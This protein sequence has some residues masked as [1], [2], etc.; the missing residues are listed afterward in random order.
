MQDLPV[1]IALPGPLGA[2]VAGWVEAEGWQVV[3]LDDGLRPGLLLAAQVVATHPCV[4]V[5][6]GPPSA[7]EVRTALQA[8]ALDVVGWPDDADRIR[9]LPS[10]V[11]GLE[12]EG[13]AGGPRR[14]TVAGVAGGV[15]TSTVALAIGALLAWSGREVLVV[16]DADLLALC[17][18][19]PWRGPGS[20]EVALLGPAGAADEIPALSRP[21][22]GV[23]GLRVLGG[24]ADTLLDT[25]GWPCDA[26]VLD[27]RTAGRM[28]ADL[29]CARPDAHLPA[30]AEAGGGV[31]LLGDGPLGSR[32][33]HAALGRR[34]AGR[35]PDSARVARAGAAG[36]VPSALPGSWLRTLRAAL[37]GG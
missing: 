1:A 24:G 2:E 36:R 16:G 34:V 30:A 21:V 5:V 25:G 29:L 27:L 8:G 7:E 37:V 11:R 18:V 28:E 31:L 22:P 9:A 13:T 12:R 15:G 17:A 35:L 19:D 23:A 20:A 26:V 14:L 32:Q 10:R 3:S 4:V 33:V 6:D